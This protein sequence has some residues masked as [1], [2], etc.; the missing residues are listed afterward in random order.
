MLVRPDGAQQAVIAAL[1]QR[2][3]LREACCPE[4]VDVGG[5]LRRFRTVMAGFHLTALAFGDMIS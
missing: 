3:D 2:P 1:S 4:S 5:E